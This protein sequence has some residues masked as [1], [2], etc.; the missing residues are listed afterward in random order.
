MPVGFSHSRTQTHREHTHKHTETRTETICKISER[1]KPKLQHAYRLRIKGYTVVK[2]DLKRMRKVSFF[3]DA[4]STI[5]SLD[6]ISTR[7]LD[8][9][10]TVS[11]EEPNLFRA[12]RRTNN[13]VDG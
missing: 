5:V 11:A 9:K 6:D 10:F 8:M 4:R 2:I 1:R 13:S 12:E 3:A 7:F